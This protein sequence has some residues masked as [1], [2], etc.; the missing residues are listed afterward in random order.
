MA[1]L[2]Q[3]LCGVLQ[4]VGKW[5]PMLWQVLSIGNK[6]YFVIKI[7]GSAGFTHSS[8][9]RDYPHGKLSKMG[10]LSW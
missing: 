10:Y 8:M 3:M 6:D 1:F 2:G 7:Q 5:V 4:T 9:L